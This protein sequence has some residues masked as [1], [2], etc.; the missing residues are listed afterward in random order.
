MN[1]PGF[2]TTQPA[3]SD[4]RAPG[5][6]AA[7]NRSPGMVQ[8]WDGSRWAG[9]PIV[10][11]RWG[12]APRDLLGWVGVWL[13]VF[14]SAAT[15]IL[16]VYSVSAITSVQGGSGGLEASG[17]TFPLAWFVAAGVI[18]AAGTMCGLI[19]SIRADARNYTSAQARI[20]FKAGGGLLLATIVFAL[21]GLAVIALGIIAATIIFVLGVIVLAVLFAVSF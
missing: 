11:N 20:A 19:A 21:T 18:I 10:S 5:W 16:T 15:G 8:Y 7:E 14:G 4:G 17:L 1:D 6:Y 13:V 9:V 3:D 2:D 12:T